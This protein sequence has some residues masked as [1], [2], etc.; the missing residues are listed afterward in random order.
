MQT[1]EILVNRAMGSLSWSP[2]ETPYAE[3]AFNGVDWF[4][5]ERTI[6]VAREDIEAGLEVYVLSMNSTILTSV[7]F[8]AVPG[9]AALV[10]LLQA[11][12]MEAV[13]AV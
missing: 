11:L 8:H 13:E 1:P 3:N 6:R 10:A 9:D 5:G 12:A 2:E 7:S 4:V